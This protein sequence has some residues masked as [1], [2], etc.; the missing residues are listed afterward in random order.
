MVPSSGSDVNTGIRFDAGSTGDHAFIRHFIESGETTKLLIGNENDPDDSVGIWQAGAERLTIKNGNVGVGVD[1]PQAKLEIAGGGN[2]NGV[3]IT[4]PGGN[5]GV[6]LQVIANGPIGSNPAVFNQK[7]AGNGVEFYHDGSGI[8]PSIE[9]YG[10]GG[11]AAYM[12]NNHPSQ[13]ALKVANFNGTTAI[14]LT[15]GYL[16]LSSGN[17]AATTG[18]TN[19]LTAKN[20]VKAWASFR[21][22]PGSPTILGSFNVASIT[23]GGSFVRVVLASN[24]NLANLDGNSFM[25]AAIAVDLWF[26]AMQAHAVPDLGSGNTFDIGGTQPDG[27]FFDFVAKGHHIT[28]IVIGSQ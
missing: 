7:G 1:N 14:E 13:P 19:T 22:T 6:G 27:G 23:Y 21:C 15:S 5:T 9:V 2:G 12:E 3:N 18:F 28:F 25:D 26:G 24:I 4:M 11:P 16:K 10:N 20:V 8:N 17:P